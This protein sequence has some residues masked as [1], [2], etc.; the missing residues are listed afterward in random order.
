MIRRNKLDTIYNVLW[1]YCKKS[2][3]KHKY[4]IYFKRLKGYLT[5]AERHIK[6]I[7]I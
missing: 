3:F 7:I 1:A 5:E 4:L 6:I 2:T